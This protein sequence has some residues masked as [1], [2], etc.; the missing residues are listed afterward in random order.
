MTPMNTKTKKIVAA[1]ILLLFAICAAVLTVVLNR[2][3]PNDESVVG[4][5]AGNLFNQGL[6]AEHNGIVY[7]SNGY[8]H[9]YLYSMNLDETELKKVNSS[10]S[11]YINVDD[12]YI[13][14]CQTIDTSK[15][16]LSAIGSISGIYRYKHGNSTPVC[17]TRELC[18]HVVLSGNNLYYQQYNDDAVILKKCAIDN[19]SDV[20]IENSPIYPGSVQNGKLYLNSTSTDHYLYEMDTMTG[21]LTLRVPVNMWNPVVQGDYVYFMD[22]ESDYRLSRYSFSQQKMEYL[23]DE[24]VDYFNVYQDMIYY[25]TCSATDPALKRMKTDGSEQEIVKPGVHENINITS[26][27]VYFNEFKTTTPIYHTPVTGPVQVSVFQA[28]K[29]AAIKNMK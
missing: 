20:A 27:Y 28:A 10:P 22:L 16:E 9:G 11:S 3:P 24:R 6:F 25:Q 14:C 23:T 26:A 12:Y 29:D 15:E 18:S 8:D 13:Y 21:A 19:S 7:F 17:L 1:L 5:T 2:V 4:N